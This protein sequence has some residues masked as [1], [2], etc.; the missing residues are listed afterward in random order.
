MQGLNL[1]T[2]GPPKPG[3]PQ[4]APPQISP[5]NYGPPSTGKPFA[6][7]TS[8]PPQSHS[9]LN[10]NVGAPN[11]QPPPSLTLNQNGL[12]TNQ[13][14]NNG[15]P[16]IPPQNGPQTVGFPSNTALPPQQQYHTQQAPVAKPP[17]PPPGVGAQQ[18]KYELMNVRMVPVN[19]TKRFA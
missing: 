4:G 8:P 2:Y 14:G 5:N 7:G 3:P 19:S 16:S 18:C 10:N 12:P 15:P 9:Q 11:Q 17:G 1:N 13:F 6:N